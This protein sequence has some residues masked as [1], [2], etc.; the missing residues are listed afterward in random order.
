MWFKTLDPNL[1]EKFLIFHKTEITSSLPGNYNIVTIIS[2]RIC[3]RIRPNVRMKNANI[4][5]L[6]L[7]TAYK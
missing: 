5:I 1:Y 4:E 7:L 2:K 6:M 3:M